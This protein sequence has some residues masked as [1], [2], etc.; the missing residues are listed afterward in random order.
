[1][2]VVLPEV[3]EKLKHIRDQLKELG[4]EAYFLLMDLP[5]EE[6]D[7][8]LARVEAYRVTDFGYSLNPCDITLETVIDELVHKNGSTEEKS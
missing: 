1:M 2:S 8:T 3:I 7:Q 6:F 5:V 4:D